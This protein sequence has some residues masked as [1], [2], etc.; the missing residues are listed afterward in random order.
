MRNSHNDQMV[1]FKKL[2]MYC[3]R[4]SCGKKGGISNSNPFK[5][6]QL[7]SLDV[8]LMRLC[9]KEL[10][11]RQVIIISDLQI[12]WPGFQLKWRG[13]VNELPAA[14]GTVLWITV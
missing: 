7:P 1:C 9:Y 13:G 8:K 11:A 2:A 12:S 5:F 14:V 6:G 4:S 10:A 3:T